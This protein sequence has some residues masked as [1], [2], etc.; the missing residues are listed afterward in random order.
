MKDLIPI[1]EKKFLEKDGAIWEEMLIKGGIP[2]SLIKEYDE[3]LAMLVKM[4]NQPD[5]WS[6]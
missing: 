4:R 1:C 6:I 3:I 5:K 2:C